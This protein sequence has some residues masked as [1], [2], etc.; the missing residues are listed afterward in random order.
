MLLANPL[1]TVARVAL[2][3]LSARLVLQ[4]SPSPTVQSRN[5]KVLVP[6][7]SACGQPTPCN[8]TGPYACC[9]PFVARPVSQVGTCELTECCLFRLAQPEA[10]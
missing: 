3:A 7:A 4:D 9:S 1:A 6:K 10:P 5:R 2:Q 8:G